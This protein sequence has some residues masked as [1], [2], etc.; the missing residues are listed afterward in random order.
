[1]MTDS[2][3]ERVMN[4]RAKAINSATINQILGRDNLLTANEEL[5][6]DLFEEL[7]QAQD[8]IQQRLESESFEEEMAIDIWISERCADGDIETLKHEWRNF[9]PS[10]VKH[11]FRH[12][13]QAAINTIS[14]QL[15]EPDND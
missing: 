8:Q 4:V 7:K 12:H 3:E 15:S 13:A 5:I 1:M 2:L 9:T 6:F 11:H 10:N 14:K